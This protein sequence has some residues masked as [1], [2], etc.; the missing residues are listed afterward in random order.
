M[1]LS[2]I[3]EK[4]GKYHSIDAYP[5]KQTIK[6]VD[7]LYFLIHLINHMCLLY[8]K[9]IAFMCGKGLYLLS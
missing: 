3:L 7:N 9:S 1:K 5:E 6:V 4:K 2:V 8:K